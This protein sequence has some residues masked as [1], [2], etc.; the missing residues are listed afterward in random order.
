MAPCVV[1]RPIVCPSSSVNQRLPSG[2]A[3]MLIGALLAVGM[4]NS[5]M[6]PPG[7]MRPILLPN[8]GFSSVNQRLPSGPAVI[9]VGVAFAV[10]SGNWVMMGGNSTRTVSPPVLTVTAA[11]ADWVLS[12]TLVARTWY[13]PAVPGAV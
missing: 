7:V 3:V 6:M 1:M 10:G 11:A 12:A 8:T 13:V 4:A 2:P 5:V 9:P